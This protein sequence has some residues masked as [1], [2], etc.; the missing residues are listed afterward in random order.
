M[1]F[2]EHASW[3]HQVLVDQECPMRAIYYDGAW[4]IYEKYISETKIFRCEGEVL[5][6]NQIVSHSQGWYS[7]DHFHLN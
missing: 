1:H 5:G 6:G 4:K 2:K 7:F 3:L